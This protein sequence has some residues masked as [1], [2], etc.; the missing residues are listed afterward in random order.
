MLRF[1]PLVF[2]FAYVIAGIPSLIHALLMEYIYRRHPAHTWNACVL[3]GGSG[4]FAGF[5]IDVIF[6]VSEQRTGIDGWLLI[7]PT[8][9][10]IVGLA[11]GALIKIFDATDARSTTCSARGCE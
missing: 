1:I 2:L 9:G 5:L 8:L 10:I 3:S 6:V 4:A 7:Y 11:V